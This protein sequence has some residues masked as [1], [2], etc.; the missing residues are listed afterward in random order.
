MRRQDLLVTLGFVVASMVASIEQSANAAEQGNQFAIVDPPESAEM[1]VKRLEMRHRERRIIY[2]NDGNDCY[3]KRLSSPDEFLKQRI[4]PALGTQVDTIFYCTLVTTL[5]SHD[6]NIAERW[7][8]LVD[9]VQSTNKHAV[10]G[11]DNMRMLRATGKDSLELVVERCHEAGVEVFW[12][13]RINDVHDSILHYDYLLSQWKRE[14]DSNFDF[15]V[16]A[17][18]CG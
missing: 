11:R 17:R 12:T 10:N 13:H 9:A 18:N 16:F 14:T 4:E 7:D 2:N 5:Y 6:T 1:T 3:L 8:G 15:W